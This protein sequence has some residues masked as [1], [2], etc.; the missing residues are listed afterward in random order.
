[1]LFKINCNL[2]VYI[3]VTVNNY[4]HIGLVLVNFYFYI[5]HKAHFN[6]I[7]SIYF[8]IRYIDFLLAKCLINQTSEV[9]WRSKPH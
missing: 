3:L 5:T 1:M 6:F 2:L 8:I 9:R 4:Y 7:S